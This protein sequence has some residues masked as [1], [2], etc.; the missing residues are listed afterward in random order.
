MDEGGVILD[1]IADYLT[2]ADG[3]TLRFKQIRSTGHPRLERR[4]VVAVAM[5][6]FVAKLKFG[7]VE[8]AVQHVMTRTAY[9]GQP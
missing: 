8:A 5:Q 2:K 3:P 7:K 1:Y 6:V 4:E 9:P